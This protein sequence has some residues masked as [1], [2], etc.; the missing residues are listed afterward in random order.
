VA[1]DRS[2]DFDPTC[3]DPFDDPTNVPGAWMPP[4]DPEFRTGTV[5]QI[6]R[7]DLSAGLI[8][9]VEPADSPMETVR[10]SRFELHEFLAPQMQARQAA[11]AQPARR[12]PARR[13][14]QPAYE[15]PPAARPK[16]PAAAA[17]A[18]APAARAP[19]AAMPRSAVTTERTV[20]VRRFQL[21]HVVFGFAIGVLTGVVATTIV[22][23]ATH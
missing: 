7:A 5:L 19:L 13:A 11:A 21:H 3:S 9:G 17:P 10:V 4:P 16:P 12:P 20:V 2:S 15:A 22:V 6:D 8:P 23:F 18:P 14:P 1:I